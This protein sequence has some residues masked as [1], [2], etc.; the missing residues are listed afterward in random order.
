MSTPSTH[1]TADAS[2]RRHRGRWRWPVRIA[3]LL[4]VL[5]VIA[6]LAARLLAMTGPG[7]SFIEARI[8]SIRPAGQAIAIDGLDGDLLG[9]FEIRRLTVSDES[10]IWLEADEVKARWRPLALLS[11]HARIDLVSAQGIS[12]LR[13]PEL[14]E[15]EQD[16]RTGS[17]G[18]P[19][20]QV[21]LGKLSIG[22][23][24]LAEGVAGPR[25]QWR[26]RQA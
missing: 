10:G 13:R 2:A 11:S 3:I 26:W 25:A 14:A 22:A 1:E 8:E 20:S 6:V 17:A 4:G 16:E 5:L 21:T 19:V 12:V 23:I 24:D 9:Q 15:S 18:L 7:R